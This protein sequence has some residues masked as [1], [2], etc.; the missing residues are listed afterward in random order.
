MKRKELHDYIRTEII[1]ELSLAEKLYREKP[2]SDPQNKNPD[3]VSTQ[4]NSSLAN[5]SQFRSK[6]E[7]VSEMARIANKI[8]LG[9]SEKVEL[10]LDVYGGSILEK[11][12]N[13]VKEAGEEGL[14]QDELAEKLG[15]GNSS[16]LNS[17]IKTLIKLKAFSKPE[18]ETKPT[19]KPTPEPTPSAAPS[20][21]ED[22]WE[23]AAEKDDWEK[24]EDEDEEADKGPSASD[25]KA[26]EKSAA[27]A[28]GGK[29]YA[30]QLPP[31]EEEKYNRLRAGIEAKISKILALPKTK[32]S[33]STDLQVLKT[34]IKRDDVK[35]LFKAKGVNLNDLVSDVMN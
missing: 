33:S 23:A 32:R 4:S 15:I 22:D 16:V 8:T 7:P 6:Y 24:A 31:E 13:L 17:H 2:G 30:K 3:L 14:T 27:K 25:I 26:A 5:D 20:G 21:D 10:A 12:I 29:G 34:L 11:L 9:D 1:N 19:E 28:T 35:K 18:K